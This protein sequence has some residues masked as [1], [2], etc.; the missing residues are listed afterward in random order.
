[1]EKR[2]MRKKNRENMTRRVPV[3]LGIVSTNRNVKGVT[4]DELVDNQTGCPVIQ[5]LTGDALFIELFQNGD[6]SIPGNVSRISVRLC[7]V[8]SGSESLS[9]LQQMARIRGFLGHLN[10]L[11]HERLHQ[12]R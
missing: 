1:M 4:G 8:W 3:F 10:A 2:V 7:H 6:E 11:C 9:N 12:R 5:L